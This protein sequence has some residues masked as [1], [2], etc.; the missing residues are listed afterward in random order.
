MWW[1]ATAINMA[2]LTILMY[3]EP[4]KTTMLLDDALYQQVKVRAAERGTSVA[5]VVEDAL[6]LLLADATSTRDTGAAELPSFAMGEFFIDIND[7]RALQEALDEG[8]DI[9]ALR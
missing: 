1:R 3:A 8:R 6:R 2:R 4:M 5:S 9:D 7:G